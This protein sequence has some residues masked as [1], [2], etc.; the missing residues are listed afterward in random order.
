MDNKNRRDDRGAYPIRPYTENSISPHIIYTEPNNEGHHLRDY[1]RVITRRKWVIL[2][3]FVSVVVIVAANTLMTEPQ[4]KSTVTIKI[5]KESPLV[6]DFSGLQIEKLSSDYY[7]TQYKILKS[8]SLARRVISALEMDKSV[9]FLPSNKGFTLLGSL[10]QLKSLVIPK[11]SDTESADLE[12][13]SSAG[14]TDMEEEDGVKTGHIDKFLSKLE[15]T[16][17][18]DSRLVSVSYSSRSPE[19]A[20]KVAN[21]LAESYIALDTESKLE[22]SRSVARFLEEQLK[23]VRSKVENSEKALNKYSSKN[24]IIYLDDSQDKQSLLL[25]RLSELSSAHST[26]TAVRIEKEAIYKEAFESGGKHP[27][28]TENAVIESLTKQYATIESEYFNLLNIFKPDYPKMKSLKSQMDAIEMRKEKLKADI[29][30]AIE[31]DYRAAVKREQ[32]LNEAL[33]DQKREILAF[34]QKSVP[35]QI[36]KR[37]VDAN[38]QLHENLLQRLKDVDVAATQ[39]NTNIQV[40]DRAEYQRMPYTPNIP[41]NIMLSII[42]GLMGGV[43]LAF[44]ME[45]FDDTV[46]DTVEIEEKIRLPAFGTIPHYKTGVGNTA[47][48]MIGH[49][50]SGDPVAEAFRSIGTFIMLS[51]SSKRPRSILITSPNEREGKTTVCIN[52]AIALSEA[53]GPG[54]IIDADL[55]RPKLHRSFGVDN[56]AGLTTCL[57]NKGLLTADGIIKKTSTAGLSIMTAGPFHP[58]P[59]ELMTSAKLK[60]LLNALY[61]MF[62][63]VIIDSA[64][65]TRINECAYLSS[66]VDG[67]VLVVKAG[68]TPANSIEQS[69]RI[70]RNVNAKVLG[71][72]LNGSRDPGSWHGYY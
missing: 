1:L 35:Y 30:L 12:P 32:Y 39:T 25:K 23:T 14:L 19:L 27:V 17:V 63:F 16:P 11:K 5:D 59:S 9:D 56:S 68:Q 18:K 34:Q 57:S 6:V 52:T 50:L 29:M 24:E 40:L 60:G 7:E 66:L 43:G 65:V 67:T 55:R 41:R 64:P 8:R 61:P 72:V 47:V 53:T 49:S 31:S 37:D 36:L 71:V 42:V 54:I 22:A 62:D 20:Q 13:D 70:F 10:L 46:R 33:K 48:P 3:F 15:V 26:A 2:V 45:Y 4:Y 38:N 28:F 44:F 69:K 58:N 21:T 51:S